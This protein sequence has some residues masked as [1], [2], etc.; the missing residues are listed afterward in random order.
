MS[1]EALALRAPATVTIPGKYLS[2]TSFKRDGT[3]VA[4]PV[5]FVA[6]DGVLLVETDAASGKAKRIGREPHILIAPCSVRGTVKTVPVDAYAELVPPG[7][8]PEFERL[9]KEKYRLDMLLL[10]PIRKLQEAFSKREV[11]PVIVRITPR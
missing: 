2:I 6:E 11:V 1:T 10:W 9:R 8:V 5:W 3:A 7:S 4:T